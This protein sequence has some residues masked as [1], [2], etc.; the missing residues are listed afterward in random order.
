MKKVCKFKSI[1]LFFMAGLFLVMFMATAMVKLSYPMAYNSEIKIACDEFG[2]EESLVRA[3]IKVESGYNSLAV[4]SV[5]A[6]GL[7]Q[8]MPETAEWIAGELHIDDF[9]QEDLFLPKVNIRMGVFYLSYLSKKYDNLVKVL[10]SYN[11]GEG[12]MNDYYSVDG[13]LNV[14]SIEILETK[15][16]ILK[17]QKKYEGYKIIERI[18]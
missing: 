4:S 2:V 11:A 13:V 15:E 8:I 3:I 12:R 6:K 7:M 9:E 1:L 5:G 14:E 16:Y 18:L 10:F 17:V